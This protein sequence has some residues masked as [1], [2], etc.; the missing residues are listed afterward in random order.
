MNKHN[1]RIIE[2]GLKTKETA[3]RTFISAFITNTRLMG[4]VAMGVHWHIGSTAD[5][6]NLHQFFYFDVSE[7]GVDNYR[8]V[9]GNDEE[10]IALIHQTFIGSLGGENISITEREALGL[11]TKYYRKNRERNHSLPK[12]KSEYD[13]LIQRPVELNKEEAKVLFEKSCAPLKTH[14][15]LIN[16]F[17]MRYFEKDPEGM[18]YLF[19]GLS[20][21][22][23]DEK[24]P[25]YSMH[26][27]TIEEKSG[28]YA[29][30]S[31]IESNGKYTLF[32]T[33][34]S[35]E[36]LKITDFQIGTPL[37]ISLEEAAMMLTHSE[38]ITVFKITETPEEFEKRQIDF[39]HPIMI[40]EH[41]QGRVYLAFN[42]NNNHVN[43]THFKLNDDVFGVCY[44]TDFGELL[45]SSYNRNSIEKFEMEILT[46]SIGNMLMPIAKYEFQDPVLFDF[47]HSQFKNF[48]DFVLSIQK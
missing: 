18:S 43:T 39:N 35:V 9:W 30:H 4:V 17:L 19:P 22:S 1:F 32:N 23:K 6:E 14:F 27:N 16:Y 10:Q 34:F 12:G 8:S 21:V 11:F 28:G 5:A 31:L 38:Y 15:E 41:L 42:S 47:V 44:V 37:K 45:L 2:G 24:T 25:Y 33:F 40:T 36:D 13:Y 7:F 3:D 26:K 20:E 29:C 48:D 46:G